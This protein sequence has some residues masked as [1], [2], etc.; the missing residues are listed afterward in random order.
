MSRDALT[1]MDVDTRWLHHRKVRQLRAQYPTTW[2]VFWCAY[3]ALLGEA[4]VA[5]S[6]RLTLEDALAGIALPGATI[7]EAFEALHGV[8]IIG[9]DGRIPAGSW[10]E[11]FGPA[12]ERLEA[13]TKSG[14]L[15]AH[16]RWQH[17]GTF[18]A[19]DRC[20]IRPHN[21]RNAPRLPPTPA[22]PRQ[23]SRARG[24]K[25]TEDQED[26]VGRVAR[27]QAVIADPKASKERKRAAQFQLD[28]L[29]ATA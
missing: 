18:E 15:A 25:E 11:W 22:I 10:R 3:M 24:V 14:K 1:R 16:I 21:Q 29:G 7:S 6:R 9:G 26:R 17:P 12:K 5:Q 23:P 27:A 13:M 8:G 2:P 28:Q 19:C 4:W 20:G